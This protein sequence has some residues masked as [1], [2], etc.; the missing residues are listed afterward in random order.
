MGDIYQFK[1]VLRGVSPMIWR[2]LLVPSHMSLA[3]LHDAIQIVTNWHDEHQY[4]FKIHGKRFSTNSPHD[5]DARKVRLIDFN[6]H[7]S[8]RFLY[9]YNYFSFWRFDVRLEK[10]LPH[11]DVKTYPVCIGTSTQA[12]PE[13]IG[14]PLAY[15]KW[16]DDR[17]SDENLDAMDALARNVGLAMNALLEIEDA[18]EAGRTARAVIDRDELEQALTQLDSSAWLKPALD[19]RAINKKLKTLSL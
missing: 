11:E 17:W 13:N 19:R 4:S 10:T 2:R 18:A 9:E 1:L 14:G 16:Q 6:L 3:T 15:M 5:T 7:V 12:L 8:E